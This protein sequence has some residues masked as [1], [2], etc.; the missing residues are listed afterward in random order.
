MND[1]I[2]HLRSAHLRFNRGARQYD[3]YAAIQRT[4]A[5]RLVERMEGW[6]EPLRILDAGCGS[7]ILTRRLLRRFPRS[8][9]DAFDI[10][11]AMIEAARERTPSPCVRWSVHDFAGFTAP[12]RYPLVASSASLHWA[13]S[14][15][16]AVANLADLVAPGGRL[17]IALMVAGTFRELRESLARAVPAKPPK[18]DLPCRADLELVM[19]ELGLRRE[20]GGAFELVT[21]HESAVD[22]LRA[23]AAQGLTGGVLYRPV[24][25]LTRG[26]L[27]RLIRDYDRAH[28]LPEGGV[29]ATYSVSWVVARRV[30]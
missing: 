22:F 25:P 20:D 3:D 21:R 24:A 12:L 8:R 26:E 30:D 2:R 5:D 19:D 6:E 27:G 14:L 16:E 13:P 9:I 29:R 17:A 15:A 23:L 28:A 10:S 7:G 18:G 11:E 1:A 4:V